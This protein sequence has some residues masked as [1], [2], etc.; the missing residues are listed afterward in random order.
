MRL[1]AR[2]KGMSLNQ[3]GLFQGVIR[4]P[5]TQ[6]KTNNGECLDCTHGEQTDLR[7]PGIL[8]ASRTEREIFDILEVV[9]A[10]KSIITPFCLSLGMCRVFTY[11]THLVKFATYSLGESLTNVLSALKSDSIPPKLFCVGPGT[12]TARCVMVYRYICIHGSVSM[13]PVCWPSCDSL[14]WRISTLAFCCFPSPGLAILACLRSIDP[15]SIGRIICPSKGCYS[16]IH[17]IVCSMPHLCHKDKL[18]EFHRGVAGS[19]CLG[20]PNSSL[21]MPGHV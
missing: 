15:T 6:K 4:D 16:I 12:Y 14:I 9:R 1:L 8:V 7:N 21:E 10:F 13:S 5:K 3:R 19:S 11:S 17:R 2:K 18:I 20:A